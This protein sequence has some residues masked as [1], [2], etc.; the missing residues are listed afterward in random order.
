MYAGKSALIKTQQFLTFKNKRKMKKG[1][2]KK[3]INK[4]QRVAIICSAITLIGNAYVNAQV[5]TVDME[6][7]MDPPGGGSVTTGTEIPLEFSIKNNG[8]DDLVV[9]DTLF[10]VF[11]YNGTDVAHQYLVLPFAI[12]NGHTTLISPSNL[13]VAL[14]N[15]GSGDFC[16]YIS[17]PATDNVMVNGAPLVVTYND[18]DPSNNMTCNPI[19]VN[20]ATSV[21]DM[22][23]HGKAKLTCYPNPASAEVTLKFITDKTENVQVSISD[24]TGREVLLRNYDGLAGSG[25]IS[26]KMDISG[27][28]SGIYF[29]T[30]NNGAQQERSK[31]I[32][33][34]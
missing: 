28:K 1:T 23:Q 15:P 18:P 20:S 2:L 25:T 5:R 22:E 10:Y 14:N 4:I 27:L 31:L 34:N 30:L 6:A 33:R 7:I 26:L 8:P 12:P 3:K 32:I 11:L 13:S 19:T 17:N 21:F 24:I 9:G 29:V 16:L